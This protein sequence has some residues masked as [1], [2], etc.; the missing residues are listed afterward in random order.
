MFMTVIVPVIMSVI[1]TFLQ[2]MVLA[3]I[4][5]MLG[6]IMIVVMAAVFVMMVFIRLAGRPAANGK[7]QRNPTIEHQAQDGESAPEYIAMEVGCE[8]G[9]I[10]RR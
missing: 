3:F 2:F 4:V 8:H 9:R 6:E 5:L 10:G 1:M 7:P